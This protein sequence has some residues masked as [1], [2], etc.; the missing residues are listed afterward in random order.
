MSLFG[1][2]N[3][4]SGVAIAY[5]SNLKPIPAARSLCADVSLRAGLP[6]FVGLVAL[7]LAVAACTDAADAPANIAEG[8]SVAAPAG[9]SPASG[10]SA[11]SLA[12]NVSPA[13]ATAALPPA[14]ASRPVSN[15][16]A[17]RA[18]DVPLPE[19]IRDELELQDLQR[20]KARRELEDDLDGL[21]H[22]LEETKKLKTLLEETEQV[23]K[24]LRTNPELR[25]LY[26]EIFELSAGSRNCAC[27]EE[28][29]IHW[30]GTAGEQA[31]QATIGLRGEKH[32]V[33]VG[34]RVGAS[35]CRLSSATAD[36]A[37]LAC[38]GRRQE[39]SLYSPVSGAH[40]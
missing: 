33:R 32:E 2:M 28:A 16:P 25:P 34:D 5:P 26:E 10:R 23:R 19:Q 27:L 11:S 3:G 29:N 13:S 9:N 39:R 15:Q 36:R 6:R 37:V 17:L 30:L 4:A 20:E 24:L 8:R 40:E 31:G 22:Y 12:T 35:G 7:T 14:A 38:G 21:N 1:R 18:P